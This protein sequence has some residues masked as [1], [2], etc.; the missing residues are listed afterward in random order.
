M[1]V[2]TSVPPVLLVHGGLAEDMGAELFWEH[3]GI[4]PALRAAGLSVIAPDRDTA[5]PSWS[6][7]AAD[8][9]RHVSTP[10]CVVAG[11][12]GVSVAVRM[13]LQFPQLVDRLVLL[14]P[15]T[16]GDADVDGRVLESARHLLAG[17][18]LRG[19]ADDELENLDIPTFVMA[20]DP[21]SAFH[22]LST[23]D[24]LVRLMPQATRI[25]VGFPESPRPEFRPRCNQF[26]DALVPYLHSDPTS[27]HPGC[28]PNRPAR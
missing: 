21:P 16:T 23:V 28:T 9:A 17:G 2:P 1:S 11:S 25:P 13:A 22:A 14:W 10:V 12:N 6:D 27:T 4:A 20:S 26:V 19:V 7:A 5:P 15:A 3:P 8:M 24:R 18:T